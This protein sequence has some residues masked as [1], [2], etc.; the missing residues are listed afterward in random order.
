MA[1]FHHP[2]LPQPLDEGQEH[3]FGYI[4]GISSKLMTHNHNLAFYFYIL[5]ITMVSIDICLYFRN[6]RLEKQIS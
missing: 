5:N 2:F 1:A 3:L 6:L 4:C